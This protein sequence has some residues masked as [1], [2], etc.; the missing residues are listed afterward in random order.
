ME[1]EPVRSPVKETMVLFEFNKVVLPQAQATATD[2][3]PVAVV[4]VPAPENVRFW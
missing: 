2:R 4:L 3:V 1:P